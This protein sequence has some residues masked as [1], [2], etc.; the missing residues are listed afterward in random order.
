[1]ILCV[2]KVFCY[3]L[4]RIGVHNSHIGFRGH[5]IKGLGTK[6]KLSTIFHPQT[7]G[8][9]EFTIQTLEDILR[10]CIIDFK[11]NCNKHF[12]LGEFT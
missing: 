8:Q 11:E 2:A 5:S 6:V 9:E 12:P 7:D 1:M 10:V 4:H 3:P